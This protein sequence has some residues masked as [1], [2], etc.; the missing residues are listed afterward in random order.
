MAV[1]F[2]GIIVHFVIDLNET[3]V[4]MQKQDKKGAG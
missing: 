4:V 3:G 2:Y 1:K